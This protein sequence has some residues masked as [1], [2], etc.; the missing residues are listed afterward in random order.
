MKRR[1]ALF[2]GER[3]RKTLWAA[4]VLLLPNLLGFLIFTLGPVLVSLGM[5]FTDW[6]L[7]R[8]TSGVIPIRFVGFQNYVDML[9]FHRDPMSPPTHF[10]GLWLAGFF[11]L[12]ALLLTT[13]YALWR[14]RRPRGLGGANP[15][16][17]YFAA[18][19]AGACLRV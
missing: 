3:Q 17:L 9:S 1:A 6:N 16:V 18:A 5:S 19:L 12:I 14:L 7:A 13:L 8:H 2:G 11:V 15:G 10:A 4:F